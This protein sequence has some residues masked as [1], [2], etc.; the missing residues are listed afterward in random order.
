MLNATVWLEEFQFTWLRI[1]NGSHSMN[2]F[3][4][5]FLEKTGFLLVPKPNNDSFKETADV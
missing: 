2:T 1:N 4:C 5:F 3:S